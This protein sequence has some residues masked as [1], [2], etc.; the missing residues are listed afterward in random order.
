[1]GRAKDQGQRWL[2]VYKRLCLGQSCKTIAD[3]MCCSVTFVKD[4]LAL[5]ETTPNWVRL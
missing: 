4:M 3:E 2:A 5:F 1:M